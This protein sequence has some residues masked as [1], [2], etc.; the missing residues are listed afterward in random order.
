M[1]SNDAKPFGMIMLFLMTLFSYTPLKMEINDIAT[2]TTL[3]NNAF[4]MLNSVFGII[5]IFLAVFWLGLAAYYAS[6]T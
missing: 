3:T 1:G 5:W 2:N 4:V 6:K